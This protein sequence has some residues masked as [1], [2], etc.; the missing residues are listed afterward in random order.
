VGRLRELCCWH[1]L[2]AESGLRSRLGAFELR[3]RVTRRHACPLAQS[4]GR[5]LR[6]DDGKPSGPRVALAY[7]LSSFSQP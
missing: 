5:L 2:R 1:L 3:L 6:V 4:T 7:F